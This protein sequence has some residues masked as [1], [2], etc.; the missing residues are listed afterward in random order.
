MFVCA[1][2]R[3]TTY[4]GKCGSQTVP[5]ILIEIPL[6]FYFHP[7]APPVTGHPSPWTQLT[8]LNYP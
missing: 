2:R 5:E 1:V 4:C 8:W 3:R 7:Q 6:P